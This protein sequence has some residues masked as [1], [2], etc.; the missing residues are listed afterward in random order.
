MQA[1][2]TLNVQKYHL[3]ILGA[4]LDFRLC[5]ECIQRLLAQMHTCQAMQWEII[6]VNTLF[7][8]AWARKFFVTHVK[9]YSHFYSGMLEVKLSQK[10]T[11]HTIG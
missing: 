10:T 1:N 5:F 6:E 8:R 11:L 3:F 4:T 2:S 7:K 9:E